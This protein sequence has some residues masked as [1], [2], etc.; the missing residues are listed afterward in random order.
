MRR[1][2]VVLLA[3]A[4]LVAV[5]LASVPASAGDKPLKVRA[6]VA[7]TFPGEAT[8]WFERERLPLVLKV[9]GLA[10]QPE[11]PKGEVRCSPAGLCV[12]VIG[13]TKAKSGPGTTALLTYDGWDLSKAKFLLAGIAG[14]STWNGTLGDAALGNIV[15]R[16]DF[17]PPAGEAGP[18]GDAATMPP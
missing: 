13:T 7:A 15:D 6:L 1:R 18:G 9:P 11:N 2:M 12:T 4:A 16:D 17:V 8:P 5:A 3:V 10:V 14:I